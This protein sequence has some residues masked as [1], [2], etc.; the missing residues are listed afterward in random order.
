MQT[1]G[2]P[3]PDS[4]V[5]QEIEWNKEFEIPVPSHVSGYSIAGRRVGKYTYSVRRTLDAHVHWFSMNE[6]I[7]EERF[8]KDVLRNPDEMKKQVDPEALDVEFS[9]KPKE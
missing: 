1:K 8:D 2:V 4:L 5:R 7:E 3:L 9:N 6:T